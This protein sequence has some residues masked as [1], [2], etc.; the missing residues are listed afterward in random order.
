M[1]VTDKIPDT[2]EISALIF[3]LLIVT[4]SLLYTALAFKNSCYSISTDQ[5][6]MLAY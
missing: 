2:S 3:I 6:L 5:L 4:P 1:D